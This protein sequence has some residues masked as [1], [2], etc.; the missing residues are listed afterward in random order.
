MIQHYV[1]FFHSNSIIRLNNTRSC[2]VV[3]CEWC[4]YDKIIHLL[5]LSWI[6]SYFKNLKDLSQNLQNR[7]Y[8]EMDNRLFETYKNSVMPHDRHIYATASYMKM[9]KI[10]EYPPSQHSFSHWKFVLYC[11]HHCPRID[12]PAQQSDSHNYKTYPSICFHIYHLIARCI[13]HGRRPLDEKKM[14]FLYLH[15]LSSVPPEKLY[16]INILL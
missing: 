13:V 2:V 1:Q 15:Y 5:L 3:S 7:R 4:I 9:S 14:C 10:C 11:C 8:G 16:T 12:L 6:N